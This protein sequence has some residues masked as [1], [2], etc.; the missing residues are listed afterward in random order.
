MRRAR[1]GEQENCF[2]CIK[3]STVPVKFN[4]CGVYKQRLLIVGF[5]GENWVDCF[6]RT[7]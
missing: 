7:P 5:L 1:M 6:G 4:I 2:I 3:Y